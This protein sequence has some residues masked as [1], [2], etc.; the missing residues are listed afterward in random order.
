MKEIYF[1]SFYTKGNGCFDL[2]SIVD[3]IKMEL[4]PHFKKMF[5]L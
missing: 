4:K 5:F 3:K 1:V 2:T